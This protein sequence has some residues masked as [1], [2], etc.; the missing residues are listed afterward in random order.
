[1]EEEQQGF[2]ADRQP[3]NTHKDIFKAMCSR[4]EKKRH[5]GKGVISSRINK[6]L[7]F[8]EEMV[9]DVDKF[10]QDVSQFQFLTVSTG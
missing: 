7:S 1:M 3:S 5:M 4:N 9:S 8:L 2:C 6:V 10:K